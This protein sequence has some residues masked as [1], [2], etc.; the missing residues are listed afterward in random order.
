MLIRLKHAYADTPP[1]PALLIV[2]EAAGYRGPIFSQLHALQMLG[3]ALRDALGEYAAT[4]RRGGS[5]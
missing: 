5:K 1:D 2:L 3:W 4:T